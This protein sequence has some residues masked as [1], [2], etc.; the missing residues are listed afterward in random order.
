MPLVGGLAGRYRM[1]IEKVW[2]RDLPAGFLPL[3]GSPP[4]PP[5]LAGHFHLLAQMKVG[6]AKCLNASDPSPKLRLEGCGCWVRVLTR[7]VEALSFLASL[8]GRTSE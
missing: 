1:M 8:L 2:G 6:K 4:V 3:G 5:G 7:H